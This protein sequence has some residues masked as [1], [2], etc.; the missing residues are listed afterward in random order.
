MA[1]DV[2]IVAGWL[3]D[4][5]GSSAERLVRIRVVSGLITGIGRDQLERQDP[6]TAAVDLSDC[7][8]LPALTDAHVHLCLPGA[9]PSGRGNGGRRRAFDQAQAEIAER[10]RLHSAHGVLS[11]RDAGDP[12]SQALRYKRACLSSVGTYLHAP[13][14]AWHASGRYGAIIGRPPPPG[15]TLAESISG[16]ASQ[17]AAHVKI[18]QSGPNSLSRYGEETVP[19]F[20][21]EALERAVKAARRLGLRTMVHANGCLPVRIAIEAGCDS[22]EH[23]Y[24]MGKDNL[25]KMAD[26]QIVWVP[27]AVPMQAC[28]RRADCTESERDTAR[29]TLDRQL[30]QIAQARALGVPIAL[31]TDSGCPGVPHGEAAW[32]ELRLFLDAGLPREEAVRCATLAGACLVG[33]ETEL[34][35]L[36]PGMPATF[37]AV[38]GGPAGLQ[39]A[40]VLERLEGIYVRGE[41]NGPR[42]DPGARLAATAA[43]RAEESSPQI[44]AGRGFEK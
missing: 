32:G 34:G 15:L 12:R 17:G 26:R 44:R 1:G 35:S 6:D 2:D 36:R 20:S 28:S 41:K 43:H 4:G 10:L 5:T 42:F 31:G 37:V 30:E 25:G 18:I 16:C 8:V 9:A 13:A 40:G 29:K 3:I 24:F 23:G 33:L 21:P 7:T 27:T 11:V 39:R 22:I 19:Q 38:K 14:A